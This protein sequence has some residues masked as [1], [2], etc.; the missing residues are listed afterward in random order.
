MVQDFTG[1]S[2]K[3][4]Q[5]I[6]QLA[7]GGGTALWDAVKFASDKLGSLPEERPVAKI[8]VVISDG[9]DNSSSAT[10]KEALQSAERHEVTV[11]TVS[12][13]E[14]AG[15]ADATAEIADRAMKALAART[16]G[17]AF[18][19]DSL[20]NLDHRL[21]DLQQVIRSRYLVSYKPAQF[22]ADGSY[23][24]IAVT[25]RKSGHKLRVYARHGYYAPTSASQAN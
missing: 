2:A 24:T 4:S 11:Y 6:D 18:F 9:E 16:G 8:L 21:S 5:G 14:F 15:G 10:L 1:D 22:K 23:R 3:I 19:P 12:T 7:P 25:A 13:R 20:G 17:A